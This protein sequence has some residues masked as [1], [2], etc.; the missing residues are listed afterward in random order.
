MATS[1]S[2]DLPSSLSMSR[3]EYLSTLPPWRRLL[4]RLNWHPVYEIEQETERLRIENKRVRIERK[5]YEIENEQFEIESRQH[6]KQYEIENEQYE[7]ES[8]QREKQLDTEIKLLKESNAIAVRF[9]RELFSSSTPAPSTS[10]SS[11][12]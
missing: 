3:P 6:E 1:T 5:Q 4:A 12:T 9:E 2:S 7:I 8:R 11:P 10:D